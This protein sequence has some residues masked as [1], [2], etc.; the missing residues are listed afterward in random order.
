MFFFLRGQV[1]FF[2]PSSGPSHPFLIMTTPPDHHHPFPPPMADPL[3]DDDPQQGA[4]WGAEGEAA[5]AEEEEEQQAGLGVV[6]PPPLGA[7]TP[8]PRVAGG[9]SGGVDA[10]AAA[11]EGLFTAILTSLA[12]GAIPDLDLASL[13]AANADA[14]GAAGSATTLGDRTTVLSLTARGARGAS[15]YA[16]L[17][18]AGAAS[19]D[20]LSTGR[21]LTQRNLYYSLKS[22]GAVLTPAAAASAVSDLQAHFRAPRAAFGVVAAARGSVGGQVWTAS[23]AEADHSALAWADVSLEPSGQP[24]PG[25]PAALA[26]LH[27]R[28]HASFLILVEKDAI[29]RRLC[30][31]RVWDRLPGGAVVVTSHGWPAAGVRAFIAALRSAA[32]RGALHTVLGVCDWNPAGVGILTA[33]KYGTRKC[34]VGCGVVAP[35]GG[36]GEGG[37]GEA[38]VP[39]PA[40]TPTAGVDPHAIPGLG[41]LGLR[42]ARLATAPAEAF[43][44]LTPRDK[45]MAGALAAGPLAAHPAWTHELGIMASVGLKADL[46]A[47][48]AVGGLGSLTTA[49][50]EDVCAGVW[51]A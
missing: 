43:Q 12:T 9:G 23:G 40:T 18:L 21:S 50:V 6:E 30:E 14:G 8:P 33:Y 3:W 38:G 13:R 7:P 28:T 39:S 37:E 19:Y 31:D 34:A 25:D 32:P 20:A 49:L 35:G 24:L 27:T 22:V 15:R 16:R 17:L 48:D 11:L 45:A 42:C 47:V 46:E 4:W 26:R 1:V 5:A 2:F 10:M 41:W 36:E 44:P 51:A 29:F